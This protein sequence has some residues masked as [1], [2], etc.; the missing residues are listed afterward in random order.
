MLYE[1][2]T[3]KD[4]YK[5][6]QR[7]V[8]EE[9]TEKVRKWREEKLELLKLEHEDAMRKQREYEEKMKLE[10]EKE[11][12]KRQADKQR[13]MIIKNYRYLLK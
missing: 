12:I 5:E 7:A 10:E 3:I 6:N 8:C 4:A 9:L 2:E 13:V 1:L 11:T